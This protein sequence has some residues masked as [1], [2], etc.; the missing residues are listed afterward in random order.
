MTACLP[1]CLPVCECE[2]DFQRTLTNLERSYGFNYSAIAGSGGASTPPAAFS[3]TGSTQLGN[4]CARACPLAARATFHDVYVLQTGAALA[5]GQPQ[6][7]GHY[8]LAIGSPSGM[9]SC[10]FSSVLC[11]VH[12][13]CCAYF[14]YLSGV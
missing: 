2:S 10:I 7:R 11:A 4:V 12:I 8:L 3:V 5:V 6:L 9:C 13:I 14:H 1:A